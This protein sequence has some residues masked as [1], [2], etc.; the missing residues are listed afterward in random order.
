MSTQKTTRINWVQERK[1]SYCLHPPFSS[2]VA[3]KLEN[4]LK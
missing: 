1:G 3:P 2:A 4:K